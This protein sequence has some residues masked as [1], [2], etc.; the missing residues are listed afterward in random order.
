M[1]KFLT[2]ITP[3]Y[4]RKELIFKLYNSL[5]RQTDQNFIWL[6]I[7]DGS[8]DGL[9]D[10]VNELFDFEKIEIKYVFKPNGGKHTALNYAHKYIETEYV[11]F[12]DSDDFL[13]DDAV[14]SIHD[15]TNK[16]Y[17]EPNVAVISFLR[18]YSNGKPISGCYP[19]DEWISNHFERLNHKI[20]GDCFEVIKT[21]VFL[22]F[23][24]PEIKNEKF[25]GEGYL[26]NMIAREYDTIYINKIVYICEYLDG[27]LTKS[28]RRMRINNPL[29]GMINSKMFFYKNKKRKYRLSIVFKKAVLYVCYAKFAK[30]NLKEIFKDTERKMVVLFALIPGFMLWIYWRIKYEK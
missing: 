10:D 12:V 18:G 24:F 28:G 6:I 25:I 8:T 23:P 29:G 27:G 5:I 15:Q 17:K 4:N 11:C 21:A 9:N 2:I 7:D 14:E 20:N 1:E 19:Y 22:N 16:L 3:V 13:T 26:W 30:L